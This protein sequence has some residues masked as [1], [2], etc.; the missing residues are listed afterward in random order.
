MGLKK[1]LK[2]NCFLNSQK[3]NNNI[4]LFYD[5][6]SAPP[7]E[8]FYKIRDYKRK[9]MRCK[10]CSH[11]TAKHKIKVS[12]FYKKNYSLISHGNDMRKKFNKINNLKSESDNYHRVKRILLYFKN[13]RKKNIPQL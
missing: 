11:F 4:E 3:S 2:C 12:E 8:P 1:I 13:L 6:Q 5:Y 10:I 9:I 7:L